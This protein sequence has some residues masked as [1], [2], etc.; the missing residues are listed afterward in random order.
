MD[1]WNWYD[2]ITCVFSFVGYLIVRAV[3]FGLLVGL[4]IYAPFLIQSK[5]DREER[6]IQA[7]ERLSIIEEN[8][9]GAK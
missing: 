7:V 8:N 3:L 2:E 1:N 9:K 5:Q 6:L 4:I